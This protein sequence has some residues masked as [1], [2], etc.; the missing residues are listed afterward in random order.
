MAYVT[1]LRCDRVR[2]GDIAND[3]CCP[4]AALAATDWEGCHTTD[5]L[6]WLITG[7]EFSADYDHGTEACHSF[8]V[9]NESFW[10]S[11]IRQMSLA[12]QS[13]RLP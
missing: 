12:G 1:S 11:G 5:D 2:N 3:S 13:Q 4:K 6:A 8:L 10:T 9:K 7:V